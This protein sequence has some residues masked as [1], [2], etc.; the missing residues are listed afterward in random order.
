MERVGLRY[1]VRTNSVRR[2]APV[3]RRWITYGLSEDLLNEAATK[4]RTRYAQPDGGQFG[5]S[6]KTHGRSPA[7]L[8]AYDGVRSSSTG[9][10][11][12]TPCSLTGLSI[13]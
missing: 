7:P 3:P 9:S 10:V 6:R 11:A 13:H 12:F 4:A 1:V 2:P 5:L 8:Q